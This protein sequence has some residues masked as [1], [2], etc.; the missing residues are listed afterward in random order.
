MQAHI[1]DLHTPKLG[2]TELDYE[3]AYNWRPR[4][5]DG[6]SILR[7]AIAD[8]ATES[9]FA[10]QWAHVLVSHFVRMDYKKPRWLLRHSSLIA[11]KK[12]QPLIPRDGLPW[13]TQLKIQNGAFSTFLGIEIRLDEGTYSALSLGDSCLFILRENELDT[14]WP[15]ATAE[16]FGSSPSLLSTNPQ[17]NHELTPEE[18]NGEVYVTDFFVLATDALAAALLQTHFDSTG[19]WDTLLSFH[20]TQSATR[21]VEFAHWI[22][23]LRRDG[24][25][26]NDDTTAVLVSFSE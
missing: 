23:Q 11:Q 21:N 8:G 6:Q 3:D 25:I 26:R 9:A 10:K 5:R 24:Q 19:L 20:R 2:N 7:V 14:A 13:H 17:R 12:W 16:A 4:T 1:T 22:N 18:I 15:I